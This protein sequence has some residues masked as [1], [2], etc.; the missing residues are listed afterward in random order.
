MNTTPYSEGSKDAPILFL[1][2]A[3]AKWEM[4]KGRPLVGESGTI[5][6]KSL[7]HS[8]LIRSE[9]QIANVLRN[10]TNSIDPYLS[11]GSLTDRGRDA[12]DDLK[13]RLRDC[14][15]RVVVPMGNLALKACTDEFAISKWRGSPT[16]S[17]I[18]GIPWAIP[19]YHPA[20]TMIGR[21][22]YINRHVIISDIKKAK[23]ISEAERFEYP[24]RHLHIFPTFQEVVQYLR[25]IDGY[26]KPVAF[27]IEIYN[28]QVSCISFAHKPDYSISIPFV[29]DKWTEE[30]ECIIWQLIAAVLENPKNTLVAHNAMFDVSFLYLQNQIRTRATIHDTMIMQRIL[31]PDFPAALQFITSIYT[32]EP[33]YKDDKQIWKTPEKDEEKFYR[34]NAKDS[35]VTIECFPPLF[36]DIMKD[37]DFRWTYENTMSLFEP[38]LYMMARGVKLDLENLSKLKESVREQI[39]ERESDLRD[40]VGSDL[41]YNSPKQC[42]EYFYGHKGI[43]PYINRK[44]SRPT[45]DDKALARIV[46]KYNL[47]EARLVQEL[48]GLSK[49]Y[50]TYLDLD[51]DKD[52]RLRCT[53]DIRGTTS[54]RLSS[55]KTIFETGMNMQN[56]DPRFK[57]FVVCD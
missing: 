24:R 5:F 12:V 13:Q 44:T 48:R 20:S 26:P 21:G 30:E 53:Y 7:Y 17:T 50:G 51:Y 47:P 14:R 37:K 40:I 18:E 6:D 15:A 56:L 33:Y 11:K 57:G 41:N 4:I 29:G 28:F 42:I 1:A 3:P 31:A 32:D 10:P 2:E 19:T 38:C 34:Y 25:S 54:G 49:L 45:V 43:K 23:R 35:A 9:V 39:K 22:P 8:G 55:K 36:E 52:G 46:R 16:P 27:D